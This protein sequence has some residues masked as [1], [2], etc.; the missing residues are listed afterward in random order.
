MQPGGPRGLSRQV[1]LRRWG[2]DSPSRKV[3]PQQCQKPQTWSQE[4]QSC[5]DLAGPLQYPG[6]DGVSVPG[7]AKH[8]SSPRWG[9]QAGRDR[10]WWLGRTLIAL[11]VSN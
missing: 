8:V 7:P 3:I 10:W 11:S 9:G 2:W 4:R 6:A 1:P 5:Q